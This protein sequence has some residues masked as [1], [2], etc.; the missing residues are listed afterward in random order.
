MYYTL[1]STCERHPPNPTKIR[2]APTQTPQINGPDHLRSTIF[3]ESGTRRT[4]R[5]NVEAL[6]SYTS[7]GGPAIP[8]G[9][10]E[11]GVT[12]LQWSLLFSSHF[13]FNS[14]CPFQYLIRSYKVYVLP[15][16]FD[17]LLGL[18]G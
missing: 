7:N 1:E 14:S 18:I 5:R 13:F 11:M 15:H 2:R 17:T 9:E 3:D 10:M 4:A 12:E 6:I 16:E 8:A